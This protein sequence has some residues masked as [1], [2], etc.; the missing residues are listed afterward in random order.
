MGGS[1]QIQLDVRALAAIYTGF[2]HP[3]EMREADLL[4]GDD[5][6][7]DRLGLAFAGP[8]PFMLDDF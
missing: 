4:D 1:G 3:R 5:A 2:C 6:D 8:R 7:I